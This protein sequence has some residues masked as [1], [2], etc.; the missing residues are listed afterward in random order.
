MNTPLTERS[1]APSVLRFE[2]CAVAI[3][4]SLALLPRICTTARGESPPPRAPAPAA[5]TA[6]LLRYAQYIVRQYDTNKTGQLESDEW[7]SM[8]GQPELADLNHDGVITV[9]EFAQYCA[10]YGAG[11]AIR[12]ST[13]PGDVATHDRSQDSSPRGDDPRSSDANGTGNSEPSQLSEKPD[14]RRD[15]KYFASLPSGVPQW[16]IQRD[17]DG[18]GQLTLSEYS[19]KLLKSEIDDFNRYD[20]N[21]DGILTVQEF[22]RAGKDAK[23]KAGATAAGEPARPAEP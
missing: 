14:R 19:P 9:E 6:K 7:R 15:T 1:A 22:L 8:R 5:V 20:S 2:S 18:D 4:L 12:L 17:A 16:F 3:V 11:R 13:L 10:N 23:S 21:R